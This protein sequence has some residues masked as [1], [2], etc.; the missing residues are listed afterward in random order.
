MRIFFAD[1]V[2]R[3]ILAYLKKVSGTALPRAALACQPQ[4]P[5]PA[6]EQLFPRESVACP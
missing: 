2:D 3:P 5:T 6:G 4:H 1:Y